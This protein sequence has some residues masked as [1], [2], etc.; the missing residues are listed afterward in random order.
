M[1]IQP[2]ATIAQLESFIART[3]AFRLPGDATAIAI[4]RTEVTRGTALSAQRGPLT[5]VRA[6]VFSIGIGFRSY[7]VLDFIEGITRKYQHETAVY[8]ELQS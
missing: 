7:F 3:R 5:V 8:K 2:L 4:V 1:I 6:R